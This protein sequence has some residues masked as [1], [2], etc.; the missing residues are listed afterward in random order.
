MRQQWRQDQRKHRDRERAMEEIL[1]FIPESIEP[2]AELEPN[3]PNKDEPNLEPN[4]PNKDEPNLELN[5]PNKDDIVSVDTLKASS[6]PQRKACSR[7]K[8]EKAKLRR[9]MQKMKREVEAAKRESEK[10]RKRIEILKKMKPEKQKAKSTEG[11]RSSPV[12]IQRKE[13]VV[14]FLCRD[15][16]SRLLP[17][18]KD[19]V[20]KNKNKQQRRVLVKPLTE[21]HLQYNSEV[22]KAH[23]LSYRQFVRY[24]PFFVTQPKLSDTSTGACLDHEDVKLLTKKL[25][26]KGLLKTTSMSQLL[27]S[28]V[29]SPDNKTCMYRVCPKCCYNEIEIPVP[30]AEETMT[31]HQWIRKS[32]S[33]GPKTYMNF[34]KETQTGTC[35]ELLNIFNQKLDSLAK[36]HYNW[37]RQAKEC[38]ALKE[39]LREDEIVLHVDFSENF[40]CKLN[41][42]VQAFHFGGSRKQATV[43]T[44]VAYTAAGSQSYATITASLRHDERAVWAHLEPVLRDVIK[45]CNPSPTILHV[46]SD[47]PG[48]QYRNKKNFYLLSTIPFLS[49]FRQVTWNFS[50]KSHGK[51]APDGVGGAVK[52][53]AD[54]AVQRGEDVQTP[55]DFYNLL[56]ERK[57]DVKFFWVTEE[58]IRRFDEAV[59]EVV[60]PVKGTLA[61]HQL[62]STETGKVMHREIYCFCSRPNICQCHNPIMVNLHTVSAWASGQASAHE[63]AYESTHESS[64][65]NGKFIMV[66]Y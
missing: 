35:A 31:W 7:W 14:D 57:S 54:S 29:C 60:P 19:T 15:E 47:G 10:L 13:R 34:V 2:P 66:N 63:S 46:M 28:I 55:E 22:Q 37:L 52:R 24:C 62:I 16:N 18:R 53:T 44:C 50:E 48:T 49:G 20:T 65:L 33:E 4:H 42:E 40:S 38:R 8:R 6:T 3:P 41:S 36:H 39:S 9:K 59:P 21:L 5:P 56:T 26:Q 43:H 23:R 64:D 32:M 25:H 27:S 30:Q 17:G 11:N 51:G 58:D 12:A 61:L 1:N 45:N